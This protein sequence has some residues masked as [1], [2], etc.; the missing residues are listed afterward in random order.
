MGLFSFMY[1]CNMVPSLHDFDSLDSLF[2]FDLSSSDIAFSDNED[3]KN[4]VQLGQLNFFLRPKSN[5]I[6]SDSCLHSGQ[7]PLFIFDIFGSILHSFLFIIN[8][9]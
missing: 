9:N 4:C 1:I 8:L 3:I 7:I 2:L 5:G 6:N